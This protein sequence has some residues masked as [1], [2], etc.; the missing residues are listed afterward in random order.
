MTISHSKY[1][2]YSHG[3]NG[4]LCPVGRGKGW[5]RLELRE[6][7][8]FV[9]RDLR[10]P[11]LPTLFHVMMMMIMLFLNC[12][13]SC[14]LDIHFLV[15]QASF[16]WAGCPHW[17]GNPRCCSTTLA[18][19]AART[20]LCCAKDLHALAGLWSRWGRICSKDTPARQGMWPTSTQNMA[21]TISRFVLE[22]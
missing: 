9:E 2:F 6:E 17:K 5:N 8:C 1:P 7:V 18:R 10:Q 3:R 12:R 15:L 16:R 19:V 22:L 4:E 14:L 11:S 13:M 21:P 20:R